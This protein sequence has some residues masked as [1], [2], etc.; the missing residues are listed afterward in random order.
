VN[1]LYYGSLVSLSEQNLIDCSTPEGNNGCDGGTPQDAFKYVAVN[2][3]VDSE[4]YYPYMATQQSCYFSKKKAEGFIASF[5]NVAPSESALQAAVGI[6][7]PIAVAIDG[8]HT[9]FQFYKS[10]VYYEPDCSSTNTDHAALAVGYG[11]LD[12]YDMWIVKN[13]W[14]TGWGVDGYIYMSRNYDNNCGIASY[15]SYP[16]MSASASSS[17]ASG[18][19]AVADVAIAAGTGSVASPLAS[20]SG[21]SSSV[22]SSSSS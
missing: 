9:S 4:E 3:G 2:G 18:S 22:G 10:G 6:V 8:S 14:G 5:I 15:A 16:V 21:G 19:S 20:S 11:T 17:S 1:G 7:A 12:G 13:Q